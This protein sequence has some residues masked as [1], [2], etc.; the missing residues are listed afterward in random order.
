MSKQA[1]KVTY[2]V[3][4]I[5]GS[6]MTARDFATREEAEWA[7]QNILAL[8]V[9]YLHVSPDQLIVRETAARDRSEFRTPE[10]QMRIEAIAKQMRSI[11]AKSP[12]PSRALEATFSPHPANEG[13]RAMPIRPF[14]AGLAFDDMVVTAIGLAFNR[15]CS[16]LELIDHDDAIT[17]MIADKIIA[18]ARTGER[19]PNK[20]YE[21]LCEWA[22]GSAFDGETDLDD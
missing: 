20:L 16:S 14:L 21:A 9:E 12:M 2:V 7:R 3:A 6:V 8:P 1:S 13:N 5:D 4:H 17:T 18:A 11:V 19:D 10:C 15:V 22:Y